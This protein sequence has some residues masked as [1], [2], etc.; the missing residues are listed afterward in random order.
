M[1]ENSKNEET[2]RENSN[3]AKVENRNSKKEIN[4]RINSK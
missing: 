2:E 3:E 1:K 4:T